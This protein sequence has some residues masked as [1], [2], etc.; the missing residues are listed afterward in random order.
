MSSGQASWRVITATQLGTKKLS[1]LTNSTLKRIGLLS[2]SLLAIRQLSI[3]NNGL[4]DGPIVCPI[5]LL[6]GIPC[7]ACGTTRSVAAISEGRFSDALSLNPLG[8]IVIASLLVWSFNL[9]SIKKFNQ[10]LNHRFSKLATTSKVSILLAIYAIT[11]ILNI[12]RINS[13]TF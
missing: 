6:T 7:P 8:F 5:R 2:L 11:W 10:E 4:N 12:F 9:A 3:H 13:A 1:Q